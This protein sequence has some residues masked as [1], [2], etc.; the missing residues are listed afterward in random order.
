MSCFTLLSLNSLLVDDYRSISLLIDSGIIK[1]DSLSLMNGSKEITD[2]G[3]L[4]HL[5]NY[6]YVN[7]IGADLNQEI[8]DNMKLGSNI[9][10][11]KFRKSDIPGIVNGTT[12]PGTEC[13]VF[14]E[15][16]REHG[17]R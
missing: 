7:F 8:L 16:I 5:N 3:V 12:L 11:I 14:F 10:I 17:L 9:K 4:N 15:S 13:K 1:A 6:R 2:I